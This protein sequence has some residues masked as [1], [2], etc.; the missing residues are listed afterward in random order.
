MSGRFKVLEEFVFNKL[1]H[2]SVSIASSFYLFLHFSI[3]IL[4]EYEWD[5]LQVTVNTFEVQVGKYY[6]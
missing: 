6:K 2:E 4:T 3:L 1:T 5:L